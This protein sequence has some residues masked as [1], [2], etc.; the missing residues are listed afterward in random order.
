VVWVWRYSFGTTCWTSRRSRCC[1]TIGSYLVKTS[2]TC[3]SLKGARI[4]RLKAQRESFDHR[5]TRTPPSA[6][7]SES[8]RDVPTR[9]LGGDGRIGE[10]FRE[11]ILVVVHVFFVFG[12]TGWRVTSRIVWTFSKPWRLLWLL[13]NVVVVV[14]VVGII[15]R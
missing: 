2:S 15:V 12:Q 13:C 9:S 7:S 4:L 14:V 8:I 3:C 1:G 11:G 6:R 10:E 5:C